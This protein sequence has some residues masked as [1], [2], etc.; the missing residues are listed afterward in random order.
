MFIGY[1]R[2]GHSLVG[3]LL[4]AHEH[5]LIAHEANALDQVDAGCTRDAL[6]L[7]LWENSWRQAEDSRQETGYSYAVPGQFQGDVSDLRVIGDKK[8]GRSSELLNQRPELLDALRR[9]LG[10]HRLRM[11]HV[12]R[13]PLDNIT[14]I[15]TRA[16][17]RPQRPGQTLQAA[18]D[19]YFERCDAVAKIR[20][21]LGAE[22]F[23][24]RLED[25]VR[26]PEPWLERSCEF[27]G[28]EAGPSYLA[29]CSKI[30][31]GEPKQ[32]RGKIEWPAER[33]GEVYDRM[34]AYAFLE[35]YV[36]EDR[37]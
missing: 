7:D 1:P 10:D 15:R 35:E 4:D 11:M 20:D 9:V 2:S 26:E 22:V 37:G 27:L 8:G 30:V 14:T 25:L 18:I 33:I 17:E 28:V 32:T 36:R 24:L 19:F 23:D 16:E 3:S 13:H 6:Y 12:T 21:R 5:I 31:F 29:D 34:S